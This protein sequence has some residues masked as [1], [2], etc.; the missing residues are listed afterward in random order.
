[1]SP[2]LCRAPNRCCTPQGFRGGTQDQT[3]RFTA[4]KSKLELT[5]DQPHPHSAPPPEATNTAEPVGSVNTSSLSSSTND[6]SPAPASDKVT[7]HVVEEITERYVNAKKP[8]VLVDAC[9]GR[10]GVA[11]EVRKLVEGCGIRFFESKLSSIP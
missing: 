10:F 8:I 2:G 5:P 3:R 9:A 4:G 7:E 1:V 11:G 6:Q